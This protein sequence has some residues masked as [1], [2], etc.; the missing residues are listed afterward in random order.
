MKQV[1]VKKP[2]ES[3]LKGLT[4]SSELGEPDYEELLAQHENYIK[5][6]EKCNVS[7]KKLSASEAF[8]DSTFVEDT[9]VLT[10]EFAIITNP[11]ADSRNGETKEM[12]SVLKEFYTGFR[13][14]NLPGSLDGGDVLQINNNFYV[15]LS[16]RTNEEGAKQLKTILESADYKV[17]IIPLKEVFHLKTGVTY[18]GNNTIVAAGE[19]IKHPDF[20]QYHKIEVPPEEE[21]TANTIRVNDYVITPKGFPKTNQKMKDAGFK[22]IKV[23]MSEFQK[24]DGG[25]SCLSLRF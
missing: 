20:E 14:I 11:G 19:F 16:D 13:Y 17:T 9:A 4:T 24:H 12:V 21:Y 15:G 7:I 10:P 1:I 6:L 18:I 5:A 25:L 23:D 2:G 8:P 3:Y 22:T